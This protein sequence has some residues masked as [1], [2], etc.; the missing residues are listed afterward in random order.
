VVNQSEI[1]LPPGEKNQVPIRDIFRRGWPDGSNARPETR[2]EICQVR[3]TGVSAKTLPAGIA[4]PWEKFLAE[5]KSV[6]LC[7]AGRT[8][9]TAASE[10]ADASF[11]K[12]ESLASPPPSIEVGLLEVVAIS[13]STDKSSG[14]GVSNLM[15]PNK[16]PSTH[17]K[18]ASRQC[19][20]GSPSYRDQNR[21]DSGCAANQASGS[22]VATAGGEQ[23]DN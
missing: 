18:L 15:S 8:V 1:I 5:L 3:R 10:L 9:R 19:G 7:A 12:S 17:R 20:I 22:S 16:T 13:R 4:A 21:R 2:V 11:Q 23:P 14:Y 6:S